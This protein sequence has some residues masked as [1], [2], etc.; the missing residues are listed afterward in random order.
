MPEARLKALGKLLRK[1]VFFVGLMRRGDNE[2]MLRCG[3]GTL[4]R[5]F[6]LGGSDV[7]ILVIN[8]WWLIGL[9]LGENWDEV[10]GGIIS[11]F[12][13]IIVK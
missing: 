12:Y 1:L 3:Q 5:I 10:K 6:F 9:D 7:C 4:T 13:E 2:K 8:G 11:R